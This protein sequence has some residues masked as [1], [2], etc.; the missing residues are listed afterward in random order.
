MN[1]N[2]MYGGVTPKFT[3]QFNLEQLSFNDRMNLFSDL[4]RTLGFSGA[5][6]PEAQ[7]E[8]NTAWM[9]AHNAANSRKAA[10]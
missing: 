9:L 2:F 4:Y 5:I 8:I 6:S 1:D 3:M 10:A 7:K